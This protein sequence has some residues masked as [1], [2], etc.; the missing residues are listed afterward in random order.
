M[1]LFITVRSSNNPEIFQRL[2]KLNWNCSLLTDSHKQ[3]LCILL[4]ADF[5]IHGMPSIPYVALELGQLFL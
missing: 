2:I 1:K 3:K 5:S 4:A